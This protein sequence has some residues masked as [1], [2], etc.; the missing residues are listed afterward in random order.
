MLKDAL[1][2]PTLGTC[3]QP[4]SPEIFPDCSTLPSKP[5]RML[6]STGLGHLSL[7]LLVFQMLHFLNIPTALPPP[8]G[9][10]MPA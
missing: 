1:S 2:S 8:P 6:L 4:G 5:V 9:V 3:I 10:P 7:F